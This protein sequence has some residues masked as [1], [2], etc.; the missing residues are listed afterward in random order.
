M[1]AALR[2]AVAKLENAPPLV[3]AELRARAHALTPEGFTSE[4]FRA[5]MR[6]T[7]AQGGGAVANELLNAMQPSVRELVLTEFANRLYTP[8]TDRA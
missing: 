3:S 6:E 7:D 8:R 4:V 1:I 2:A 5:M